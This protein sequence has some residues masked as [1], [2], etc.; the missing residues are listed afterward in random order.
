MFADRSGTQSFGE[1]I[2]DQ[3]VQLQVLSLPAGQPTTAAGRGGEDLV[4]DPAFTVPVPPLNSG[5]HGPC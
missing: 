4:S 3:K 2:A 1:V 5:G